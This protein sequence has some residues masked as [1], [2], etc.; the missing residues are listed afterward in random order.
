MGRQPPS[1][2]QSSDFGT[3][4]AE[5]AWFGSEVTAQGSVATGNSS[6]GF[7]AEAGNLSLDNRVAS[8][9]QWGAFAY[10]T[11]YSSSAL[12]VRNDTGVS[13]G[14]GGSAVSWGNNRLANNTNNGAFSS[15]TALQ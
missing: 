9:N 14:A 1:G 7:Y 3:L 11:L 2:R 8:H 4:I 6:V 10:A 12:L 15:T 5:R 13:F